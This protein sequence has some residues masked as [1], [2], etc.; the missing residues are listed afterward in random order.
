TY[1][2]DQ[3]KAIYTADFQTEVAQYDLVYMDTV[4]TSQFANQL[5]DLM[6]LVKQDQVDLAGFLP[7]EL[8][9]KPQI[10]G[11]YRLPMRSDVGVL[12]YR[13]DLLDQSALSLP[14]TLTDLD[15]I[16]NTLK[17]TSDVSFGYLW[18]GRSYEGLVAN[19]Y[20]VMSSFGATWIDPESQQ[21]GLDTPSTIRAIQLLRD[22]IQQGISPLIVTDYTEQSSLEVF[23]QGQAVFLRGWPYF[24]TEMA[25]QGW[26]ERVAIALPFSFTDNPGVGCRG[27]WG[28]GISQNAAHPDAAWEAIKYFTSEAAQKRF[29]L[30]SGFLPSRRSL[31]QDADIIEQYPMMPQMLEFLE[32][33]SVFRPSIPQYDAASEILQTALGK[34]LRGQQSAAAALKQAQEETEVLLGKGDREMGRWGRGQ[35][36][37]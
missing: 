4:W 29:V 13:K 34:I 16:V 32:H 18:Q 23:K 31:F 14:S 33:S 10:N 5:V 6:P 30:A 21:V 28:F 20:E 8:P 2:T 17:R 22:L 36:R 19:V 24:W 25:Q 26:D 3:R 35:G 7:S 9:D 1:T 12:Y 27:G 37:G 15:Q 11:L